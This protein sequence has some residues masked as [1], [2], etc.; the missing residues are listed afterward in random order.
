[1]QSSTTDRERK[2]GLW[3]GFPTVGVA[4]G[5]LRATQRS[6]L[7]RPASGAFGP[8]PLAPLWP[9]ALDVACLLHPRP[10]ADQQFTKMS[11]NYT[12]TTMGSAQE[13]FIRELARVMKQ[14]AN[15]I[16]FDF[17]NELNTCWRAPIPQGDVCP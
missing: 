14:H 2:G 8:G 15:I 4:P 17:G 16:G 6:V 11:V 12:N 3:Q 1:M 5:A 9:L 10:P 13:L 7:L